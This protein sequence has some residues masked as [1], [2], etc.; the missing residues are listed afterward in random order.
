MTYST[1]SSS[2]S[3]ASAT[4]A[5]TDPSVAMMTKLR[6]GVRRALVQDSTLHAVGQYSGSK[7]KGEDEENASG[8]GHYSHATPTCALAFARRI[9]DQ[10]GSG[11]TYAQLT[12][13]TPPSAAGVINMIRCMYC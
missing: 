8:S 11:M 13:C 9:C 4:T 5:T 2:S 1:T 7:R 3:S 12:A 6:Q 10:V